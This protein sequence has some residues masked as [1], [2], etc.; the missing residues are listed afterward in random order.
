MTRSVLWLASIVLLV[1]FGCTAA[2][3][4]SAAGIQVE[5]KR[6]A[7][8]ELTD[9]QLIL[10][11]SATDGSAKDSPWKVTDQAPPPGSAEI[12]ALAA[13]Q[14]ALREVAN[15]SALTV[16]SLNVQFTRPDRDDA[17][18]LCCALRSAGYG[19]RVVLVGAFPTEGL[20]LFYSV[21]TMR[22]RMECWDVPTQT[23]VYTGDKVVVAHT[24]LLWVYHYLASDGQMTIA[25]T[26]AIRSVMEQLTSELKATLDRSATVAAKTN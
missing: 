2:A 3:D 11:S 9:R 17:P 5:S 16:D 13:A 21:G 26:N 25:G 8:A 20:A 15:V 14:T 6:L 24:P 22:V 19:G 4:R 1:N 23:R 7:P 12:R 18:V 10:L